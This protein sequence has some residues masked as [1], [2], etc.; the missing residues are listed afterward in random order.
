MN[1]GFVAAR[2]VDGQNGFARFRKSLAY[3]ALTRLPLI[4]WFVLTGWVMVN[5]LVADLAAAPAIDAALAL[6]AIARSSAIA[7]ILFVILVLM[8]RRPAIARAAGLLPRLVALGGAFSITIFGLLPPV[9]H[10]PAVS[11]VSLV[12]MLGGYAFSCYAVM[13]LGRSLSLMAE[14]RK[15]VMTGPYAWVRHPLYAA[16]AVASLGVLLQ[17]LSPA[18]AAL[19][20]VHIALQLG[21]MHYEERVLR[22]TFVEYDDYARRVARLVPGVY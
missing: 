12:L 5:R 7:F 4:F 19:W 20:V 2:G 18:A 13:H 14:A 1:D 10:S 22:D 21:R 8:V 3:D 15:L 6:D 9:A 17:Y 11:V 16:E